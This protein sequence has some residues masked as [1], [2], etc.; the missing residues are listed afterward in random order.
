MVSTVQYL[1]TVL[2]SKVP[3]SIVSVCTFSQGMFISCRIQI[4]PEESLC[5]TLVC[6]NIL[7]TCLM[8]V[9]VHGVVGLCTSNSITYWHLYRN[10]SGPMNHET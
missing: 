3:G 4:C 1:L 2:Y 10:R 9:L 8:P 6:H 7:F 5:K